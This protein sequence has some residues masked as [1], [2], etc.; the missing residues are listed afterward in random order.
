MIVLGEREEGNF[1]G[2]MK[3]AE[4]NRWLV[5][6]EYSPS[7]SSWPETEPQ[8]TYRGHSATIT[9]V[10]ISSS[11]PRIY[12]ASLDSVVSVWSLPPAEHETYAP[13]DPRSLLAT[14]VGHTDAIWDMVLLPL[15]LRDEGLLATVSADGTVK[16]WSTDELN[17]PLKLSWGYDGY[18]DEPGTSNDLTVKGANGNLVKVTPTS[19]AVVWSDLKK[20]AVSYTNS[21]IKLFELENGKVSLRLKSDDT[22]GSSFF[23]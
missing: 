14:F 8:I 10:A 11:P 21:V 18:Q 12:S 6:D 3:A 9:S 4:A 2:T 5:V 15:R 17:S 7:P 19:V 20:V 22:F 1:D 23:S 13:Y 16:V